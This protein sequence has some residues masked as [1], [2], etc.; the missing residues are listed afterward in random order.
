MRPA[1]RWT[2]DCLRYEQTTFWRMPQAAFFTILLPVLM[3][4]I[5]SALNA[6]DEIDELGDAPVERYL[7]VGMAV[8]ALTSGAYGNLA[9]RVTYRRE[10]GT[11]Q[12]FRTTPVPAGVLVTAQVLN[13]L[14][15][16]AI[17]LAILFVVSATAFDVAM[18]SSWPR[19]ALVA[20]AGATCCCAL[21][22]AASTFV[23]RLEAIDPI[24]FATMLPIAF[25]S[26]VFD[27]VAEDT[28]LSRIASV[29]PVRHILEGTMGAFGLPGA[30][31]LATHLAVLAAWTALGGAVAVRR[32]R[33]APSR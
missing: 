13:A 9:A 6:G 18:P 19:F 11:F 33:W 14:L 32:F 20:A 16:S 30:G 26:G 31:S 28:T 15:V 24:V 4:S 12:R 22:V 3:L 23:S 25:I 10:T 7:L 2:R 21:G 17:T 27:H 1:L 8:F 29:F 5:F